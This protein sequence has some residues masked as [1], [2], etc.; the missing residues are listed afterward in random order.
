M[1]ETSNTRPLNNMAIQDILTEESPPPYTP[2]PNAGEQSVAFGPSRP[3]AEGTYQQPTYRPPHP[4]GMRPP[5]PMYYNQPTQTTYTVVS[6]S[7]YPNTH[8]L[9]Y[10]HG[11]YCY[12]CKNTGFKKPGKACRDCWS[13]FSTPAAVSHY[14]AQ[15]Y[16]RPAITQAAPGAGAGRGYIQYSQPGNP[17]LGGR[18]CPV[19]RGPGNIK[20]PLFGTQLCPACKGVGRVYSVY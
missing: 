5:Q 1:S 8:T 20:M 17:Q 18:L 4:Q 10:P 15:S 2:S 16:A 12:K 9:T 13:R 7:G 19:C 14:P 3:W 6:S 11:H